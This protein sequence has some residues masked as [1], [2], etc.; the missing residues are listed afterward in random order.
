MYALKETEHICNPPSVA[1]RLYQWG[2]LFQRERVAEDA[3]RVDVIGT[4]PKEDTPLAPDTDNATP[5]TVVLPV[6]HVAH[7][8]T[9]HLKHCTYRARFVE[10]TTIAII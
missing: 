10:G 7:V 9:H 6:T 3:W 1:V 5:D 2:I 8:L 4:F